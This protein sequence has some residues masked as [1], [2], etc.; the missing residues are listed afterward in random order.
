MLMIGAAVVSR[1]QTNIYIVE[2]TNKSFNTYSITRPGEFLS[3]RALERRS[4]YH[5]AID[6]T[7]LPVTPAYIDSIRLAGNVTILNTS[8]WL[9]QVAIRTTDNN[10]L[11]KI[12]SF[13]FV[14]NTNGANKQ[15]TGKIQVANKFDQLTINETTVNNSAPPP[16]SSNLQAYY[17]YGMSNGQ[18]K[19]HRGDFLHNLGFRGQGMQMAVLDAGFTNYLSIPTFDSIRMNG[20]VLGTWDFVTNNANVNGSFAYSTHGTHCLSTIAANMPG[21]FVGTAPQTSFYLFRTED[22]DTEFPIEEQNLSAGLE[23]ADSAG[24]NIASISLG[25]YDF[26]NSVYNYTYADMDGNTSLSARAS[27]LAAKKGMLLVIAN[28]NE[29]I[30]PW[31][32]LI[33]PADADSVLAVGAVDTLGNVASFSSYGP[34]SDGQVKPGVAAVGLNAVIANATTGQPTYSSG[35]SFACPNMAGL[36]TCL[37]QAFPEENNMGIISAL[38]QSASKAANPDDRVGYGIPDMRKAFVLLLKRF[39]LQDIRQAGCNVFIN[40]DIKSSSD[41]S[42]NVQRKLPADLDFVTIQTI[43]GS[44]AFAKTRISFTDDLTTIAPPATISY[45]IQMNIGGDT[46]FYFSPIVI[47]HSNGCLTY[48]FTGNGNWSS[49]ANWDNNIV[50]PALLPKGSTIIINPS[51][52]G[53]CILE[54]NQQLEAGAYLNVMPGKNFKVQGNLQIL[55]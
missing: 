52:A 14:K 5:I 18:V 40:F 28:G 36:S 55:Q 8:K 45:R 25:Y 1:A 34:S 16:T 26:D 38:Q 27:D 53:E 19:I 33:T 11:A 12:N 37:W 43:N 49:A 10:A 4:L 9:N 13:P 6:S 17:N 15:G 24:V 54:T 39:Y 29:G 50:P 3:A 20:Q 32:Y 46:S 22:G 35:T 44:G 42:F 51:G 48:T 21:N 30:K 47:N 7:D 31:Q 23:R 41:M 2:L